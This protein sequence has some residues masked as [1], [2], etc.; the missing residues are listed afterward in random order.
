MELKTIIWVFIIIFSV[1]AIITLLGITNVIKGIKENYLN[2]LFYTL[3]I[4][5][6]IAVVAVFKGVDF[7]DQS[8]SI[9]SVSERANISNEFDTDEKLADYLV[10]QLKSCTLIPPLQTD[11]Q[12]LNSKLKEIRTINQ[13]LTESL[14]NCG[15][16][17]SQSEK[18][19]Y[20]I[21]GKLRSEIINYRG[22]INLKFKADNKEEVFKLLASIFE[23]L[24]KLEDGDQNDKKVL[25]NKF[26]YFKEAYKADESERFIITEFD[27]SMLIRAYLNQIYPVSGN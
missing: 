3:I 5:V 17:L 26:R 23:V 10:E 24:G 16:N 14:N 1:T 8:I 25:Q 7:N 20:S 18:S 2:K 9:H 11:T 22:S 21:I 6:V 4:E 12:R 13:N 27:T 15:E 19:F